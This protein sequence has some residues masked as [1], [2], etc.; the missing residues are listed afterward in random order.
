ML[1]EREKDL[2]F[3][4]LHGQRNAETHPIAVRDI[5]GKEPIRKP[6]RCSG[7]F[8]HIP[9]LGKIMSWKFTAKENLREHC[10]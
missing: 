10:W 6:W 2:T 8:L 4:S 9:S 1:R 7:G 5:A 3:P